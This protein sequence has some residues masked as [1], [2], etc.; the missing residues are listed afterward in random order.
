VAGWC[1][2][3]PGVSLVYFMPSAL[4][5]PIAVLIQC[6]WVLIF[7]VINKPRLAA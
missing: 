5:F 7:T 2:W 3:I 1:I 6:F 4:Q